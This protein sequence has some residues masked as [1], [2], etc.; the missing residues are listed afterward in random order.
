MGSA[1]CDSEPEAVDSGGRDAAATDAGSDSGPAPDDAP[2]AG[3]WVQRPSTDRVTVRWESE[4][5]PPSAEVEYAP[6]AGGAALTATGS[7]TE[8]VVTFSYGVDATLIEEP[9]LPGTFHLN[10]VEIDGLSPAT[11]YR[12]T[13]VGHSERGGRFCT[14]HAASDHTTPIVFHALGDT[15]PAL[16]ITGPLLAATDPSSAEFVIHTGDLQYYSAII[17]TWAL[18]FRVMRPMLEGAVFLPSIGNHEDERP[19]EFAAYYERLFTP[20]G[21]DGNA[22][23]Y[24]F[25]TGGVHFFSLSTQHD[26]DPGSDR[27]EWLAARMDEVELDP[28]Y[29]FTILYFH[30]PLYT[31]GD[32]GPALGYRASLEPLIETHEVPLV[33]A[34]HMHGYERFEIGDVT[35]I[36][37]AGG[38]SVIGNV[39]ENVTEYPEDAARRVAVGDYS[40]VVIITIEGDTIRGEVIDEAGVVR[41]SFTKTSI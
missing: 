12:Y 19:G 33:F 32:K 34:G 41:D 7:S 31:V 18:W 35:Y 22:L 30:R 39:S 11:C 6:V 17:E 28:D 2:R 26:L 38:G 21:R 8:T 25:E 37:T 20:A 24:H 36:T 5:A 1:A 29:R 15:S 10:E 16:G 9:D 23:G 40:H 14:T 3:P 13:I 4:L 27:Y